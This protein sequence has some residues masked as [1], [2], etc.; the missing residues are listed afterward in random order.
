M[1]QIAELFS[2]TGD[3]ACIIDHN[4]HIVSWNA[5]AETLLGYSRAE[6]LGQNCWELLRG[7]TLDKSVFCKPKCAVRHQLTNGENIASLDLLLRH[8]SGERVLVNVSTIP[9]PIS[10]G[11]RQAMTLVHLWRPRE[12]PS[13]PPS[14]RLRI[15]LLG[16]TTITRANGSMVEG[17]L[18]NRLKVRALFAY[19]VINEGQPVSRE[20]LIDVL[21]PDLD[22][23]A[24]L[25]N[26]NTAVYNLRHSLEP[27][28]K[29]A[30]DSQFIGY[31]GGFYYLA[32]AELYWLDT[33]AFEDGI[34][35]ARAEEDPVAKIDA[36]KTAVALYRGSYL[37]DLEGTGVWSSSEQV[38][39]E[40]LY[41]AAMEELGQAYEMLQ[42]T[43]EAESWYQHVLAIEP[44]RES[45]AQRLIRLLLAQGRR[46]DALICCQQLAEVLERELDAMLSEESSALLA[47]IRQ[48][49]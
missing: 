11:D 33:K 14:Q 5:A 49:A 34:R 43:K 36:Y 30:G 13:I 42:D 22:Y 21:W 29:K 6:A 17:A 45:T 37:T 3:G 4:Q 47:Q 35:Q 9:I 8:R 31:Q 16:A 39:Y 25:H 48:A 32:N 15:H 27:N 28:V 1:E 40:L 38:R 26:L 2:L 18:W 12:T 20:R 46:V 41:L 19:L 24:A 23:K 10:N 7:H 44:C